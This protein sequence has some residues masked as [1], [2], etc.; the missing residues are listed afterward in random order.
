MNLFDFP[1]SR[2]DLL[3]FNFFLIN[4]CYLLPC[5]TSAIQFFLQVVIS[6]VMYVS[7][8]SVWCIQKRKRKQRSM[9]MT[10]HLALIAGYFSSWDCYINFIGYSVLAELCF[11]RKDWQESFFSLQKNK[12]KTWTWLK[13]VQAD[14]RFEIMCENLSKSYAIN[15]VLMCGGS[16]QTHNLRG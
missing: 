7:I 3:H 4:W 9:K 12:K 11:G 5:R 14:K 8:C 2:T 10:H 6:S 15:S 13:P 16:S 1:F